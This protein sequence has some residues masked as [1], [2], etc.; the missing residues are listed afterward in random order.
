MGAKQLRQWHAYSLLEPFGE[1]RADLRSGIVAS[2]IAN[3]APFKKGG[4]AWKPSDFMPHFGKPKQQS[5]DEIRRR[6]MAY[7]GI[8]EMMGVK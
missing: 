4:K 3:C 7:F 1:T 5:Q 8:R 2:T 6:I